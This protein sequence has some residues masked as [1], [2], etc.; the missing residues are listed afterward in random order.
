MNDSACITEAQRVRTKSSFTTCRRM[1]SLAANC[2][3]QSRELN[4]TTGCYTYTVQCDWILIRWVYL[5][6]SVL[7]RAGCP[8]VN[9]FEILETA[10]ARLRRTTLLSYIRLPH[11][12]GLELYV[13][14]GVYPI[15]HHG[16]YV[17]TQCCRN[18]FLNR[19][20]ESVPPIRQIV[21]ERVLLEQDEYDDKSMK[22]DSLE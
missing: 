18:I 4:T 5:S 1:P 6:W 20:S 2:V 15:R 14:N 10:C 13:V 9:Y 16:N 21:Y 17:C 11:V 3:L 22:R 7:S 19:H 8:P 12:F